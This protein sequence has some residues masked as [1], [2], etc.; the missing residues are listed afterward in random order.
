MS[1]VTQYLQNFKFLKVKKKEA[2]YLKRIKTVFV[3]WFI[4]FFY[5]A[6]DRF[7]RVFQPMFLLRANIPKH[8]LSWSSASAS[9]PNLT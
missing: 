8:A 3:I 1:M 2:C 4:F 5:K 9:Q 6:G 7:N